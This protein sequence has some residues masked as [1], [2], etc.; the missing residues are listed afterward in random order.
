MITIPD[1]N[2]RAV[3]H[4]GS[5]KVLEIS[6]HIEN[7]PRP[8]RTESKIIRDTTV[9]LGRAFGQGD[10]T[11]N[12]PGQGKT[13]Q[14]RHLKDHLIGSVPHLLIYVKSLGIN[15]TDAFHLAQILKE[16][17]EP[18]G[19]ILEIT[20]IHRDTDLVQK[21]SAVRLGAELRELSNGNHTHTR[22]TAVL[23]I[24]VNM[25]TLPHVAEHLMYHI[26]R[27]TSPLFAEDKGKLVRVVIL[28]SQIRTN[29][30]KTKKNGNQ[31]QH[32]SRY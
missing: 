6:G 14:E 13:P 17:S 11:D 16:V 9:R 32:T 7:T 27:L 29:Q 5:I 22:D 20:I 31:Q 30:G 18:R 25:I 1:R 3:W 19:K 10:R 4:R 2:N 23:H 24:G 8:D 12:R 15:V 26:T 28:P 21:Q